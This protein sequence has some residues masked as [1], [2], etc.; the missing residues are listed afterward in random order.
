MAPD[1]PRLQADIANGVAQYWRVRS[2]QQSRQQ[3]TGRA[4][5]GARGAVT[6][7]AQM[8]SLVDLFRR[9]LS[10]A[11][12]APEQIHTKDA[13]LDLPG[14]FRP[15]KR[16]D[17]VVVSN[18]C[19]LAAIEFKSQAGPSFSNNFNNRAEEAIG[20]AVDLT[21]AIREGLLGGNPAPFLGYF[22]LLE[23]CPASRS[24]VQVREPHFAVLPEYVSASFADRYEMLCRKL[25]QERHYAATAFLTSRRD[26]GEQGQYDEP[27]P[28]MTVQRFANVLLE[29]VAP[30]VD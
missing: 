24:I 23:D 1:L 8:D 26:G 15:T 9:L 30:D 13:L 12:I 28:G 7:G 11:G 17:L 4:D 18:G 2:G 27:A 16:W 19:L 5:R 25:Y 10:G 20:S 22:F 3:A 29:K 6:G 21:T 14:F